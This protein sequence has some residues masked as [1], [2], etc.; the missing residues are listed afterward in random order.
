MAAWRRH[1]LIH[2]DPEDRVR[3]LPKLHTSCTSP[4]SDTLARALICKVHGS[5]LQATPQAHRKSTIVIT[6]GHSSLARERGAVTRS[7]VQPVWRPAAACLL[8][9]TPPRCC[10]SLTRRR[11]RSVTA[12]N[13]VSHTHGRRQIDRPDSSS[14]IGGTGRHDLP[15]VERRPE[16][17]SKTTLIRKNGPTVACGKVVLPMLM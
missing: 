15:N 2:R 10:L 13:L 3:V 14:R 9:R 11:W 8:G 16:K 17:S 4:L 7:G 6:D 5:R 12:K 1:P